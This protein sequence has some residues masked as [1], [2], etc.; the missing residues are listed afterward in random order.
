M[1]HSSHQSNTGHTARMTSCDKDCAGR[2]S[3]GQN[4]EQVCMRKSSLFKNGHRKTASVTFGENFTIEI[5]RFL[6]DI[7]L[8]AKENAEH[9]GQIREDKNS[10][11]DDEDV[12][13]LRKWTDSLKIKRKKNKDKKKKKKKGGKKKKKKKK[14]S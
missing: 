2:I 6:D 12:P 13:I 9:L 1:G 7:N 5:E 10:D 8:G 11:N 14:K 3:P 4:K